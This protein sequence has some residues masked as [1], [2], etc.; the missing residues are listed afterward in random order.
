MISKRKKKLR[1][2]A[3]LLVGTEDIATFFHSIKHVL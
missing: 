1:N 2:S 3:N